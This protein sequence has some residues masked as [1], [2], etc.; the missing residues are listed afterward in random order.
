MPLEA[1]TREAA[2]VLREPQFVFAPG[3]PGGTL[4]VHSPFSELFARVGLNTASAFLDLSGEVV[5]GHADRHVVRVEISGAPRAFY[6]KR[7]HVV[8]AREKLRN[9]F[10]G[11][12]GVS[13]CER[14]VKVL[15]QLEAAKLPAPKWA[16]FGAHRGRTFLLVEEAANAVDLRRLL[17]DNALSPT[18]RRRLA[19]NIGEAIAAVHA[20]GFGTPDLTAKHILVNRDT[21]AV[22]F[23]DWQSTVRGSVSDSARTDALGALHASLA[24]SAS[25]ADRM[26][27]LR[28][29]A[30]PQLTT[31]NIQRAA[32]R[33]S[34]RRSVRDQLQPEAHR[35]RLVWLAGEAVC[36]VP[37]VAAMWPRPVIAPPFYGFG[38]DGASRVRFA[39]RDAILIRGITSA[40]LG[41]VRSWL[42][43]TPWRSPGVT[44]GRVLFHLE[45]YGVPASRL[46]AFGQ[47]LTNATRAEWFTLHEAPPG[48]SLRKWRRSATSAQR[49][50]IFDSCRECL[51][52]L[53]DAGCVLTDAKNA[54]ALDG[55]CALIGDPRAVRIVR[56]VSDSAKRR[57]LRSIAR[58]LGVE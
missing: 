38:P 33:H 15:Q 32:A 58:L 47:R 17:S 29:Y 51:S 28:A 52:K 54:L 46:L 5:S 35:Q 56:R 20:A 31:N 12:G 45:R 16:A 22:T 1:L 30:Q 42:R 19:T 53:H 21:L 50:A 6:L 13:R 48:E 36:A 9:W 49:R 44:L 8:G 55:A 4:T 10:A 23:L 39:G 24:P 40:P 27:A 14:E 57:D 7:Q 11:F 34:L 25:R 26:R 2:T 37:E 3:E 18:E 41:R 43:A